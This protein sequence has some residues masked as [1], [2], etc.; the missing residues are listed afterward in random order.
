MSYRERPFANGQKFTKPVRMEELDWLE[1]KVADN[2]PTLLPPKGFYRRSILRDVGGLSPVQERRMALAPGVGWYRGVR[3]DWDDP[4]RL[5]HGWT[6]GIRHVRHDLETGDVEWWV[7]CYA[8]SESGQYVGWWSGLDGDVDS[9][10]KVSADEVMF[11]LPKELRV[12]VVAEY[13]P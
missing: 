12:K 13:P 4:I 8:E 2:L 7:F 3:W 6:K 11:S 10:V 9:W 1:N 5:R